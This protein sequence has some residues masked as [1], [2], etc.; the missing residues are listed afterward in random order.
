[1]FIIALFA[2]GKRMSYAA[3]SADV[4]QEHGISKVI[5]MYLVHLVAWRPAFPAHL[6]IEGTVVASAPEWAGK[7]ST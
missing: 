7:K 1:L 5:S 2:N 6:A 4:Q 3:A